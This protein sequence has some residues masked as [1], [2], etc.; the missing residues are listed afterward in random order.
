MIAR[1]E[2]HDR[3]ANIPFSVWQTEN[4]TVYFHIKRLGLF[5]KAPSPKKAYERI[6]KLLMP[7]KRGADR[8][9]KTRIS[10]TKRG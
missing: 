9:R 1:R 8:I 4:G 7:S 5:E 2:H 10:W 6:F 3:I